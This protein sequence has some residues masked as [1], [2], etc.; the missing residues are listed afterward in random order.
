MMLALHRAGRTAEA[1]H[2]YEQWRRWLADDLGID[3]GDEL[4]NLHVA[5]LR[6]DSMLRAAH[7]PTATVQPVEASE[8]G[9]TDGE[10]RPGNS[11]KTAV[12]E[13]LPSATAGIT[14]DEQAGPHAVGRPAEALDRH[15]DIRNRLPDEPA[16]D[17]RPQLQAA[18]A[19]VVYRRFDPP[20][21][22]PQH[23]SA[24]PPLNGHARPAD[25]PGLGPHEDPHV[26]HLPTLRAD[27]GSDASP[28][29]GLLAPGL[30]TAGTRNY[31]PRAISDFTGRTAAVDHLL[32]LASGGTVD[33]VVIDGMAGAGKTTLAVRVGHL[34]ADRYPDGLLYIDLHGHSER[35]PVEP[36]AALDSLLRQLGVAAERMPDSL[37]DRAAMWRAEL[38]GRWALVVLDNAATSAQ[39]VALLGSGQPALTV[40]TSRQRLSG[41]DGAAS[42]SLDVLPET[43]AMALLTRVAGA[44]V[45]ADP[46]TAAEVARLCGHL[47]LALRLA[48][49][50][51][52]S[53]PQ[54][55]IAD[56]ARRL[57]EAPAPLAELAVSG[58]NVAAAFTLS[59]RQLDE[60]ARLVF[61][62]LGLHPSGD[63][64][65]HV[66]AALADL[67]LAQI[68]S[69]LED[70]VDAHLLES[71]APGRYRL[72]DLLR[73]YAASLS[74]TDTQ[75]EG[76]AA[77]RRMTE[78]YLHATVSA[79]QFVERS[80]G[81]MDLAPKPTALALPTITGPDEARSWL[82]AEWRNVLAVVRLADERGWHTD[83]CLLARAIWIY[84]HSES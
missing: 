82:G 41:V 58:R 25:E 8:S 26:L 79:T 61:R 43:D 27:S 56:L 40:V 73:D 13:V 63:F 5:I 51:L 80:V 33:V 3:P 83:V 10:N 50:R 67:P 23:V 74:D 48:A 28:P 14:H 76:E 36:A 62:W 71:P 38:S 2:E 30:G 39:V 4:Q 11:F 64:G 6:G 70:L 59:Y 1:L 46:R 32:E 18:Q 16:V 77:L 78:L 60:R 69:T 84:L 52:V 72:H 55:S 17:P 29:F 12:A 81:R 53:R 24:L 15:T 45:A 65:E 66:A 21:T 22:G 49:A 31:L 44:R 20:G 34:L 47:P 35:E 9:Q 68:R 54:W 57:R 42:L 7:P 75:N 37:E 19:A